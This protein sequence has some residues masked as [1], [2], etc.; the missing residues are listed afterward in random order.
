MKNKLSENTQ[1]AEYNKNTEKQEPFLCPIPRN[2]TGLFLSSILIFCCDMEIQHRKCIVFHLIRIITYCLNEII[3]FHRQPLSDE[4]FQSS[5][6]PLHT[7]TA[8]PVRVCKCAWQCALHLRENEG[9][10]LWWEKCINIS[11]YSSLGWFWGFNLLISE[12]LWN[13]CKQT[14]PLVQSNFLTINLCK[15]C[16]WQ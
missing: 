6:L 4:Q 5:N 8:K 12:K 2:I 3:A 11:V 13:L 9:W 10:I 1:S 14:D 15:H 7:G 16:C